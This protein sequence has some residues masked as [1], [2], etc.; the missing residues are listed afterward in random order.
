MVTVCIGPTISANILEGSTPLAV[1]NE[2]VD[3]VDCCT[4]RGPP[5]ELMNVLVW[6]Y[7]TTNDTAI[8]YANV[9]T[10]D[11]SFDIQIGQLVCSNRNNKCL[12]V[13]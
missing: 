12:G 1:D 8:V 9:N 5:S 10:A 3:L 11:V 13:I 6:Q 4:I 2:V 7:C